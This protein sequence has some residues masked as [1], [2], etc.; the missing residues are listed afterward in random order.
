MDGLKAIQTNHLRHLNSFVEVQAEYYANC[1]QIMQDLQK[2][3]ARYIY[4]AYIEITHIKQL[5]LFLGE[6]TLPIYLAI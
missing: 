4:L 2:E 5:I 6:L 3:L 1:N